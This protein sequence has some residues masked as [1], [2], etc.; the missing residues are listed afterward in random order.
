MNRQTILASINRQLRL[1]FAETGEVRPLGEIVSRVAQEIRPGFTEP[2]ADGPAT[3]VP[4]EQVASFVDG[5]VDLAEAN[6]ICEAVMVDNSVLA[7][8][9]AAVRAMQIP[10]DQLP[11]L[12]AALAAQLH[13][14]PSTNLVL[15]DFTLTETETDSLDRGQDVPEIVVQPAIE[16]ASETRKSQR[17]SGL[18]I[19]AGLLAIA[20][21][22]VVAIV[23]L[24]AWRQ[25]E[26]DRFD[27]RRCRRSAHQ[28]A[29][30]AR[31]DSQ[32]GY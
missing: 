8:L 19:A 14:M 1:S 15:R 9:V 29:V 26:S 17:G 7:E 25:P 23:L 10:G 21:T 30:S 6:T 5:H 22:I 13:A 2:V 32:R 24:G 20:A 16:P 12:S 28:A 4:I 3:L 27:G 31:R 11:P 18:G